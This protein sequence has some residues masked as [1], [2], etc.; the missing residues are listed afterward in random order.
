MREN[1]LHPTIIRI[2]KANLFFEHVFIKSFANETGVAVELYENDGSL[3][4]ALGA[5]VGAGF[6]NHIV[7]HTL[8]LDQ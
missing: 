8:I 3:G 4:A 1:N 5:G 6:S 2:E 7:K